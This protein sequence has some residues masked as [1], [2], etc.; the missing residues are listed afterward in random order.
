MHRR[1]VLDQR[2]L[3]AWIKATPQE[4][5]P[6][7]ANEY[8]YGA[9]GRWPTIGVTVVQ[10]RTLVL[11][12][13]GLVLV[14]GLLLLHFPALRRRELALVAGLALAAAGIVAPEPALLLAEAAVVGSL[15]LLGAAFW[16]KAHSQPERVALPASATQR[17]TPDSPSTQPPTPRER[18][19]RSSRVTTTAAGPALVEVRP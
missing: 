2:Q 6:R 17:R 8:L 10:R 15:I 5:L 14:V 1:P 4:T 12:V 11:A 18:G 16:M 3:E 9:I 19:D 13:S 7:G